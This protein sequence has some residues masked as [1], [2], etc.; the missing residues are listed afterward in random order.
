M[1][2]DSHE[3]SPIWTYY[4]NNEE[5]ITLVG[6]DSVGKDSKVYDIFWTILESS[7]SLVHVQTS[8][9]FTQ[10]SPCYLLRLT[11]LNHNAESSPVTTCLTKQIRLK[12]FGTLIAVSYYKYKKTPPY[13]WG[14]D[15]WKQSIHSQNTLYSCCMAAWEGLQESWGQSLFTF[16]EDDQW[17]ILAQLHHN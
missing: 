11:V 3:L 4:D 2:L 8:P 14:W 13:V 16:L 6:E 17:F 7:C 15:C 12:Y 10:R 9:C 1:A 5:M